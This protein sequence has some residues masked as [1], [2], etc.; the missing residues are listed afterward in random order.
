VRTLLETAPTR[1]WYSV[2]P[3]SH[4]VQLTRVP[5]CAS[6][7]SDL[8]TPSRIER[9]RREAGIH[10]IGGKAVASNAPSSCVHTTSGCGV[11]YTV[12]AERSRGQVWLDQSI[13]FPWSLAEPLSWGLKACLMVSARDATA[14]CQL[15]RTDLHTTWA[16]TQRSAVQCTVDRSRYQASPDW[17]RIGKK[18]DN[19]VRLP[20]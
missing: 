14:C 5:C 6:E 8:R 10:R 19:N 15:Q 17:I 11:G 4:C 9:I 1:C 13:R 7:K 16:S 12:V 2:R 18:I 3:A 20:S